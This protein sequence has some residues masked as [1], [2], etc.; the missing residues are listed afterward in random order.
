MVTSAVMLLGIAAGRIAGGGTGAAAFSAAGAVP[1]AWAGCSVTQVQVAPTLVYSSDAQG[2]VVATITFD[3]IPPGCVSLDY[4]L[5]LVAQDGTTVFETVG[6][7]GDPEM[8][9][10]AQ[11]RPRA[12]GIASTI[13]SV[14]SDGAGPHGGAA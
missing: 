9:I 5:A 3:E 12:D 14:G 11:D 8:H 7:L 10:P 13:L 2:Y 1:A 4:H 6:V